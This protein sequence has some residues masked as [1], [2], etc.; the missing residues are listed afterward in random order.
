MEDNFYWDRIKGF[1]SEFKIDARWLL[2]KEGAE[3]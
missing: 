3:C 2:K 1:A